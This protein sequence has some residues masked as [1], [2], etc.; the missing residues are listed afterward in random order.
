[1]SGTVKDSNGA[2]IDGATVVLKQGST[3]IGTQTTGNDG[4]Y[5]FT[6]VP[7]GVYSLII[8]T[9]VAPKTVTITEIV[10]VAGTELSGIENKFLDGNKNIMVES[11]T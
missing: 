4:S 8:T 2:G 9:G 7:E 3:E 11:A 1:M 10:T 5:T 6:K